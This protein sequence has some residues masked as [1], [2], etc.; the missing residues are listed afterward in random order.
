MKQTSIAI[1]GVGSVGA[2]IA[3]A[4]LLRNIVSEIILIDRDT[5]RCNGEAKDLADALIFSTTSNILVG[6][7]EDARR[8]D[9]I[10]IAAGKPQSP[11]QSR[12]ELMQANVLIVKSILDE[13]AG[14]RS[15]AILIMVTNPVDVLTWYVRNHFQLPESQIIG[16]G[17][18]L[19]SQRLKHFLAVHVGVAEESIQGFVLGEHGDSQCVAWSTVSIA[20]LAVELFGIDETTKNR[21]AAAVKN[22]AYE[23]IEA[24][25]ATFYGIATCIAALCEYIIFDKKVIVPLSVYNEQYQGCFS[26]PVILGSKGIKKVVMPH[27]LES[28]HKK[29]DESADLL[30]VLAK[31][32]SIT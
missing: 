13:L 10:V 3:Y 6:T 23:I 8:A 7:Y 30:R 31:K 9:I 21:I 17:T 28:E 32:L 20:G 24:K 2:T 1:I 5:K 14:V 15:D 25:G 27:L 26:L 12:I 11:G 19:D 18:F 22:E 4:L 29:L 16:S